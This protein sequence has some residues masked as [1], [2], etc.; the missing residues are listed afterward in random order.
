MPSLDASGTRISAAKSRVKI[1]PTRFACSLTAVTRLTPVIA[2]LTLALFGLA[3]QHCKLERLPGFA[4]LQTCCPTEP[5]SPPSQ[6]C[7]QDVCGAVESGDYRGEEM[8][9]VLSPESVLVPPVS[10]SRADEVPRRNASAA[11]SAG[12]APPELPRSWQFSQRTARLP[13]APSHVA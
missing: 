8:F 6:D 3:S 9:V 1:E 4:F 11:E 10:L 12:P 2:L 13:R 5:Q 7:S